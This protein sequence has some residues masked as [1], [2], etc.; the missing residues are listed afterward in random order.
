VR[1]LVDAGVEGLDVE[2]ALLVGGG[3]FQLWLL[4]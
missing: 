4:E 1:Q 3:G 2:Q